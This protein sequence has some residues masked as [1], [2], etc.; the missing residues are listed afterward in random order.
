MPFRRITLKATKPSAVD[1]ESI[2]LAA[3]LRRV[4]RER[5]LFQRE[6]AVLM[7]V[8]H[9]SVLDWE[10]GKEPEVRMYPRIIQFLGFE[11]WPEPQTLAEQLLAERRRRGRSMRRAALAIGVDEGTWR[12]W[13]TGRQHQPRERGKLSAFL[14]TTPPESEEM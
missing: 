3:S 10:Q 9:T 13:E 4:R 8:S 14:C 12:R 5:G 2:T 11:P 1:D 6:V 7:G